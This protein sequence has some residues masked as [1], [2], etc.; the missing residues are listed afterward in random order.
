MDTTVKC[1]ITLPEKI[2]K[3][4]GLRESEA[5]SAIKRELAVYLFQRN[6]LSFGQARQLAD[7]SVW[8]FLDLL[9]ERKVPLHYGVV[10]FE[11]DLKTIQELG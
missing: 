6:M 8:D 7:L 5:G 11:E 3:V 10:E 9:R 1:E 2:I 4:L